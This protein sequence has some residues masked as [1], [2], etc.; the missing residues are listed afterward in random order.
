MIQMRN[1]YKFKGEQLN[2][3][4]KHRGVKKRRGHESKMA[5][6]PREETKTSSSPKKRFTEAEES[7]EKLQLVLKKQ[8][9]VFS[10]LLIIISFPQPSLSPQISN[11][12]LDCNPSGQMNASVNAL[13]TLSYSI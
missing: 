6:S 2:G 10:Q 3:S 4:V 8:T 11:P 9:K 5:S 1:Q 7:I 13:N 12:K